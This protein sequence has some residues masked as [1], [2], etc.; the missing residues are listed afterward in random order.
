MTDKQK[1]KFIHALEWAYS[2]LS[3]CGREL[4]N[5]RLGTEDAISST[6]DSVKTISLTLIEMLKEEE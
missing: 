4:H 3:K 5:N 6:I 1:F 2:D